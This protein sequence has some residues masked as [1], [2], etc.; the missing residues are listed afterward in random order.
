MC[1]T[2]NES[3]GSYERR[4]LKVHAT[5]PAAWGVFIRYLHIA[6]ELHPPWVF[7]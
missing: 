2:S 1:P 3:V 4:S 7:M 6:S 5:V